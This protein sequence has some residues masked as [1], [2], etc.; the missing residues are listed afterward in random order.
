M[1]NYHNTSCDLC[2]EEEDTFQSEWDSFKTHHLKGSTHSQI[3][4]EHKETIKSVVGQA[5]HNL[6]R[7]FG[8]ENPHVAEF[9]WMPILPRVLTPSSALT[10][11]KEITEEN[12]T[13][14]W[15]DW[16]G[17]LSSNIVVGKRS[18]MVIIGFV[19]PVAKPPVDAIRV[20]AHGV[21]Y[22]VWPFGE[23]MEGCVRNEYSLSTP[24][25]LN[26]GESLYIQQLCGR[27]G[28][29]K[30]RP[31]GV[32]FMTSDGMGRIDNW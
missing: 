3:F 29:S 1:R 31:L 2:N 11:S 20:Y 30:L 10:W 17:T 22:P 14:K 27:P 8:G 13:F 21:Q 5:K 18:T 19:D 25:I 7:L 12:V 16:I 4:E 28:I 24:L 26:N 9:G 32:H 6:K 23:C 15:T